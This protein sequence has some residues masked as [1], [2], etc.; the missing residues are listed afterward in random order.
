MVEIHP[1]ALVSKKAKLGENVVIGSYSIIKDDVEIDDNTIVGSNSVIYDGARIGK[2][3]RI[4]NSA[5]ISHIPQDKKFHGEYSLLHIGD[6]SIIC[7]YT[8]LHRGTEATGKTIIGKN[9]IIS[10][11]SHV[12]HD[13]IISD[14]VC[15]GSFVQIG[16][17]V[18]IDGFSVLQ[19]YSTVHQFCKIGK[20][21]TVLST[22]KVSMDI[23]PFIIVGGK[24][25]KFL[26]VNSEVFEKHNFQQEKIDVIS[27]AFDI[28]YHSGLNFSQAK[29][30][31]KSYFSDN[32]V[33]NE[34]VDFLGK[35]TRGIVGK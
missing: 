7:D 19:D 17:H 3:V 13:C 8:T 33:I 21:V 11:Y 6:N 12:A 26:G 24:P 18:E 25:I 14:N 15:I 16:G 9:V 5:S 32:E 4:L 10:Q 1:T 35:C 22:Y 34:I 29:E 31:L 23:P 30:K 2:N 27:Q 28:L 20:Y